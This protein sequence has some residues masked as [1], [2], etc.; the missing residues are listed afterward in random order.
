M[1]GRGSYAKVGLEYTVPAGLISYNFS[2][3]S[4]LSKC[5]EA[6]T[7]DSFRFHSLQVFPSLNESL[8]K[9]RW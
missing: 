6:E 2:T 8:R 1:K 4:S 9:V 7:A 3:V 5:E